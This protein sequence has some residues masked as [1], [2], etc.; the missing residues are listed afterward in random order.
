MPQIKKTDQRVRSDRYWRKRAADWKRRGTNVPTNLPDDIELKDADGKVYMRLIR[1][2]PVEMI[3][4]PVGEAASAAEDIDKAMKGVPSVAWTPPPVEF[5][6]P[7][8]SGPVGVGPGIPIAEVI[9]P[10]VWAMWGELVNSGIDKPEYHI[11]TDDATCNR[12]TMLTARA[13]PG[14]AISPKWAW[15]IAIVLWHG[16]A[17]I[18]FVRFKLKGLKDWF[19]KK[20]G[21]D[22]D[23]K[24]PEEVK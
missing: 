11:K 13:W 20:F 16:K 8:K 1:G 14:V 21:K 18:Y 3:G 12:L 9:D 17:I 6:P 23:K 2:K 19:S 15:G 4:G 5:T 7:S 22:K 10:A 24:P